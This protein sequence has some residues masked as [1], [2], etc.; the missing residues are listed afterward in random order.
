MHRSLAAAIV[1]AILVR[2]ILF[3]Y[4]VHQ[5][6][7]NER[8]QVVSPVS[9]QQ[10]LD[11]DFYDKSRRIIAR[12]IGEIFS[13]FQSNY[14]QPFEDWGSL[15]I[16][17]P[18]LPILLAIFD[19]G[20]GNTLPLAIIYLLLGCGLAAAWLAW[21]H[22][23]NVSWQWLFVF[24]LVP[25]PIWFALNISTDLLFAVA[26]AAF[27]LVYFPIRSGERRWGWITALLLLAI[28]TR[29]NAI[30]IALFVMLDA[31]FNGNNLSR[32]V[33][34]SVVASIFAVLVPVSVYYFPYLLMFVE[35]S[36]KIT[37]F[38]TSQSAYLAG[39]FPSLPAFFD[40]VLSWFSLFAA[41]ILYFCGLRPSYADTEPLFVFARAA[42]GVITL[43]GLIYALTRGYRSDKLLLAV[44]MLPVFLGAT[45]DR[46]NLPIMPLLFFYG[47]RAY[48]AGHRLLID[49]ALQWRTFRGQT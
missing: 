16:S 38:G 31:V 22:S 44:F 13:R 39:V 37:Y 21:L 36:Q 5:P 19:Y 27:Y 11:F 23:K 35:A 30:S 28:A 1:I 10:G 9:V 40:K 25:N 15:V 26:F 29:P 8:R 33:K 34:V 14:H 20:P 32:R 18:A 49:K 43:P 45:Q 47:V 48:G 7:E 12:G 41:K 42:V 6:L 24:S 3:L 4:A 17:S 2:L 46:Y